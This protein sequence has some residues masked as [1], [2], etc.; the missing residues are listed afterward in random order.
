MGDFCDVIFLASI[1]GTKFWTSPISSNYRGQG[2]H[3]LHPLQYFLVLSEIYSFF[4][5]P[6]SV[7]HHYNQSPPATSS[8]GTVRRSQK[9]EFYCPV[10]FGHLMPYSSHEF[11]SSHT[12]GKEKF[13]ID[14]GLFHTLDPREFTL[15]VLSLGPP[16][17]A[18]KTCTKPTH[19][20]VKVWWFT[21]KGGTGHSQLVLIKREENVEKWK[22]KLC[23]VIKNRGNMH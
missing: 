2:L 11:S 10:C 23:L 16:Y 18:L 22:A 20:K 1:T 17:S 6:G 12:Q 8:W 7:L 9:C 15:N 4:C 13:A 19:L 3:H 14:G 5:P 21:I